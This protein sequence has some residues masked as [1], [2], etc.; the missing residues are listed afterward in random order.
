MNNIFDGLNEKQAEAVKTTEGPVLVVAGAGS[1]KTKTVT[2]RIAYLINE[3]GISLFNI[4]AITFT[5]KAAKE[6]R[7]RIT[8]MIGNEIRD[9]WIMTFHAMCVQ[10]LRRDI[11]NIGYNKNFTIL[12][13]TDKLV[14]I[15]RVMKEL[16]IDSKMFAPKAIGSMISDLKNK[17]VFPK[18]TVNTG[19]AID[20]VTNRVYK[21][22]QDLLFRNSSL[23][24]DDLIMLSIYLFEKNPDVLSYYQRKFKYIHVD[25][26]QDTNKIQF[27]LVK[28]LAARHHNICAVGDSDQA[29]YS[30]RGA[31]IRNILEF[32]KDFSVGI[33]PPKIIKLEQNYRSYQ[34]ILGAANDIIKNNTNRQI[35]K[36]WTDKGEGGKISYFRAVDG[37]NEAMYV[38]EKIKQI[39]KIKGLKFTDFA[40]LYRT[41][42]MSRELETVFKRLEVPYKVYGNISYFERKEI[43]DLMSYLRLVTNPKDDIAFIRVV[44]EPKRGIGQTTVEKLASIAADNDISLYETINEDLNFPSRTVNRLLEFKAIIDDLRLRIEESDLTDFIDLILSRSGYRIALEKEHTLEANARLENL[45]E[46]KSITKEF[47]QQR[48]N[49]YFSGLFLPEGTDFKKLKQLDKLEIM[50]SE[51]SLLSSTEENDVESVSL[52]TVHSAKGLEFP[53]VFIVGFEDRIFPLERSK[54]S[55][56]DFEEERRLAYVA[57]TRAKKKV[58]ITTAETRVRYGNRQSNEESEFLKEIDN[59]WI[60]YSGQTRSR[61]LNTHVKTNIQKLK[62]GKSNVNYNKGEKINHEK[63]GVGVIISIDAEIGTIAFK[64]PHGVKKMLLTHPSIKKM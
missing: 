46:F 41:N 45:E 3:K 16:N 53:V 12:D 31:D 24:F 54:F 48:N 61:V 7:D 11:D 21:K 37:V 4:L 30:W 6:M 35:K 34:T 57:I 39:H 17:Y 33:Y 15:K 63:F 52:M 1:G 44:N 55:I 42:A 13:G 32:E 28:M 43:K 2:H 62:S 20:E 29:I 64:H 60:E 51:L 14:I 49:T 58:F 5:N 9:M 56:E 40:V 19:N 10:I 47:E 8:N 22:Y 27:T 26:Y 38:A 23:D 25:E 36:L 50:L 59:K 18:D